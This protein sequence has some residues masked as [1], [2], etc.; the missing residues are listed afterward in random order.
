MEQH[1]L[2]VLG[3]LGLGY[4]KETQQPLFVR[5][6]TA[7]LKVEAPHIEQFPDH[8]L[9]LLLVLQTPRLLAFE[10]VAELVR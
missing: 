8:Q 2:Q 1:G 7:F 9:V 5:V 10:E 4:L 3:Q 6:E